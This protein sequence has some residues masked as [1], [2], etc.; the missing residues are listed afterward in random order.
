VA[1]AILSSLLFSEGKRWTG[2]PAN[3]PF[4]RQ[5]CKKAVKKENCMNLTL[6]FLRESLAGR[7]TGPPHPEEDISVAKVQHL[8]SS[9]RGAEEHSSAPGSEE[10]RVS[11]S[12]QGTEAAA[13]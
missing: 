4:Y 5:T 13:N 3:E 1:C 6:C 10:A 2:S 11:S 9:G 12:T 8:G 7:C